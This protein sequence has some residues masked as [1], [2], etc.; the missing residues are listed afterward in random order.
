MTILFLF[1][2]NLS[3]MCLECRDLS[4]TFLLSLRRYNLS[5]E[6]SLM[7]S[8]P[9]FMTFLIICF[10]TS[11]S[12]ISSSQHGFLLPFSPTSS[13]PQPI[14]SK[15]VNRLFDLSTYFL[16]PI[17][18]YRQGDLR[19]DYSLS[20]SFLLRRWPSFCPPHLLDLGGRWIQDQP[21]LRS[22][23]FPCLL[24]WELLGQAL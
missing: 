12:L 20:Q 13:T 1:P 4:L 15:F 6:R 19:P 5:L 9:L 7:P 18:Q 16:W 10:L 21:C 23:G 11:P 14:K 24:G 3:D 17:I 2:L 22:S 8:R